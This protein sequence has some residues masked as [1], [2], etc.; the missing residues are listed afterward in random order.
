M[1]KY[2]LSA[3]GSL[4]LA[5]LS[6]APAQ[7]EVFLSRH[8][9]GYCLDANMSNHQLIVWNCHGGYNQ[10]FGFNGYGSVN[11]GGLCLDTVPVNGN[12]EGQPLKFVRCN[13]SAGQRWA[14]DPQNKAIRNEQGWC[15]DIRGGSTQRGAQ[16]IAWRCSGA[17]NQQWSVGRVVPIGQLN[18]NWNVRQQLQQMDQ[19]INAAGGVVATGGGNVVATGGGNVVATGGGNIVAVG[20]GN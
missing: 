7:A 13:N 11:V 19:R 12:P 17:T 5:A 2:W 18:A 4:F 16:V 3:L 20:G 6:A 8:V 1:I 9:M 15:T 10:N 14:H